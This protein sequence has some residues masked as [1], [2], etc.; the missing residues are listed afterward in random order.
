MHAVL[1]IA[2]EAS[3]KV[4][5]YVLGGAFALWAVLLSAIGLTRPSF[6]NG[7]TGQ[8]AVMGISIA[9]AAGTIVAAIT[10]AG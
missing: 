3:E 2:A 8:A 6:P 5:F 1:V 9:L 10:T 4:P 7:T